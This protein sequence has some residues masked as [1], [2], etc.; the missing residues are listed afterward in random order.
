MAHDLAWLGS[1][2]ESDTN[3]DIGHLLLLALSY[4]PLRKLLAC[5]F[6]LRVACHHQFSLGDLSGSPATMTA[7]KN[8]NTDSQ[9]D[10][11]S[12]F[13]DGLS[14]GS[15]SDETGSQ[16]R[17]APPTYG[18]ATDPSFL[19]VHEQ[20]LD[21][22]ACLTPE[23][24]INININSESLRFGS[25]LQNAFGASRFAADSKD[26]KDSQDF[27]VPPGYI[28]PSLRGQPG[29]PCPPPMDVVIQVVGSRGDVQPFVA[30]GMLL[31]AKYGHRVR[32]ATHPLFRRLV[33]DNGLEFFSIGGD[34]ME[35][36]DFMVRNR[37][38]VPTMASVRNGDVVK[39]RQAMAQVLRRCW[40]SCIDHSDRTTARENRSTGPSD[41]VTNPKPFVADAIIA[42]PPSLAHIHIA[43]KL[44]IPL[45]LMFTIPWS[46]TRKFPNPL[47]NIESSKAKSE[48]SNFVSYVMVE[49]M[50]WQGLGNVLNRFRKNDLGL[51]TIDRMFA[52]GMISRLNIPFSYCW[53]VYRLG[54]YPLPTDRDSG[55][56]HLFPSQKTGART[57]LF[58]ATSCC[59]RSQHT[60]L[61]LP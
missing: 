38:M 36:M 57:S 26:G 45:H 61:I 34:P 49:M 56:Q 53:L 30:L 48:F 52:P 4:C 42:N 3:T 44:G 10:V 25:A 27:D 11:S 29:Q 5:N 6:P 2:I 12:I 50:I 1:K 54:S 39:R 40:R 21:A 37:G 58:V 23:G 35:L 41:P 47:V 32:L 9:S 28:P 55:P 17:L 14:A 60:S 31:K 7:K 51:E 33:Q 59:L 24:R 43:E 18:E 15:S 22:Q 13:T 20:D 16:D 19:R 46:P 8:P